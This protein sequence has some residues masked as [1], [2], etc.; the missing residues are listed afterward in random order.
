MRLLLGCK[1]LGDVARQLQNLSSRD[2]KNGCCLRQS[3]EGEKRV[4]KIVC[5][6]EYVRSLFKSNIYNGLITY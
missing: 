2:R 5:I 6:G 3:L 4:R 1:L